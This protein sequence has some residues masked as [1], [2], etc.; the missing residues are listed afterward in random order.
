MLDSIVVHK[1]WSLLFIGDLGMQYI[2]EKF[3]DNDPIKTVEI[4]RSI[5][6]NVG[7]EE[8][9]IKSIIYKFNKQSASEKLYNCLDNGKTPFDEFLLKCDY[10]S[11][12]KCKYK[13]FCAHEN[14][15]AMNRKVG[16]IYKD[17]IHG[18]DEAEFEI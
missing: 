10:K 14:I 11:C 7:L 17:F 12:D 4:I 13:E 6:K 1:L 2:D 3:K 16:E 5:L 9:K 8:A 18:Q 15:A